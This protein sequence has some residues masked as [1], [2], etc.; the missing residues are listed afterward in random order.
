[1]I[2]LNELFCA[3]INMGSMVNPA[4]YVHSPFR[5]YAKLG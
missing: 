2:R 4:N 5:P 1:V 3:A